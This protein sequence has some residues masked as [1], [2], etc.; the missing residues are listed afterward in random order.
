MSGENM[1]VLYGCPPADPRVP[2]PYPPFPQPIVIPG[3]V[4][5]PPHTQ[6]VV[7]DLVPCAACKRH[8]RIGTECPFCFV[9]SRDDRLAKAL[10]ERDE[11]WVELQ[12]LKAQFAEFK[13]SIRKLGG[14]KV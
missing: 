7:S 1:S 6:G 3:S 8:I 11:A 12:Q 10:R 4:P 2:E 13:E 14:W 5:W 9:D